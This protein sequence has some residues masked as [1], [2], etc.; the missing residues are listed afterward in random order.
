MYVYGLQI[1]LCTYAYVVAMWFVFDS[2]CI[3]Q[4][5]VSHYVAIKSMHYPYSVAQLATS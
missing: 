5:K 4:I 3:Q 2:H 1:D